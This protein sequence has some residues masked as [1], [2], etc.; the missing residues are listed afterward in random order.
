MSPQPLCRVVR[1]PLI[2]PSRRL[3]GSMTRQSQY[4]PQRVRPESRS[5]SG[6]EAFLCVTV[7]TLIG[8]YL[9][10][11]MIRGIVFFE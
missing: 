2:Y 8:L 11:G 10:L 1:P 7:D 9:G 4:S 5:S 6:S 3:I